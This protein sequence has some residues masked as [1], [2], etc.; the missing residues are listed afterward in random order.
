[1]IV[2][3]YSVCEKLTNSIWKTIKSI[4]GTK[5]AST[6]IKRNSKKAKKIDI[7]AEDIVIEF[8]KRENMNVTLLSE[9]IGEVYIGSAP[10][11]TI[12]LD[13]I[14]GTTNS[15]K[16][17][18]FFST[19][20]AIAK[21]DSI[22]DIFFGYVRNYL[23]EEIF[24]VNQDGAFYN[25]RKCKSSSCAS[26]GRALISLYSYSY[27]NYHLI[28]KILNKIRKMRLLGAV[29]IEMAYVGCNKLEGLVDLRGDLLI[30]DIAAGIF[31][32][33]KA[34]GIVSDVNGELIIGKLDLNRNFS[35]IAT[36]NR[37][38]HEKILKIIKS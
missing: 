29:S 25:N 33:K 24:Y 11:F 3:W 22:Q 28:R 14:D 34:G 6:K 7:L 37:V 9:E 20:I 35:L 32:L 21:G 18:P 30:S 27:V 26:L 19:S 38:L 2:D 10:E 36:G 15:I 23:A 17:L 1:M 12:I 5:D 13:P 16:A 4:V 31:F 8:L